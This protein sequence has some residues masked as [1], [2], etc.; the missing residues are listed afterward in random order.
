M[1]ISKHCNMIAGNAEFLDKTRTIEILKGGT[2]ELHCRVKHRDKT[3]QIIW[4]TKNSK[5]NKN[6]VMLAVCGVTSDIMKGEREEACTI[7][8]PQKLDSRSRYSLIQIKKKHDYLC[9]SPRNFPCRHLVI[10]SL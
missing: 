6:E 1:H 8:P 9:L 10:F 2:A 7:I 5:K 4:Y 3:D